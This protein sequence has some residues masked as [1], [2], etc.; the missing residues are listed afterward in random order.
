MG[1]AVNGGHYDRLASLTT[2]I[3]EAP[4][5]RL[6]FGNRSGSTAGPAATPPGAWSSQRHW[7]AKGDEFI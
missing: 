3:G 2:V 7:H 1:P 6:G 4:G 5:L